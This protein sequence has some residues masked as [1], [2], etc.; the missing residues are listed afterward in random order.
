MS[1]FAI[2]RV[3]HHAPTL[4]AQDHCAP[5]LVS[6]FTE[7]T[8]NSI[9][10]LDFLTRCSP[11]VLSPKRRPNPLCKLIPLCPRDYRSSASIIDFECQ[12]ESTRC[13]EPVRFRDF[14]LWT[15]LYNRTARLQVDLS[16]L[17][18]SFRI[19]HAFHF[20]SGSLCMYLYTPNHLLMFLYT[21]FFSFSLHVHVCLSNENNVGFDHLF[22]A[23]TLV[24]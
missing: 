22:F 16:Y 1:Q 4:S 23:V 18:N 13:T 17:L 10:D 5:I 24:I 19:S 15:D 2:P 21:L 9:A 11:P 8:K 12:R 20:G 3:S 6:K 14:H 7:D